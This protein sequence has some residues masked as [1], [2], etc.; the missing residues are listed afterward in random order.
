MNNIHKIK[1]DVR[2]ILA[3]SLC[4]QNDHVLRLQTRTVLSNYF[5]G[6]KY[7]RDISD[8]NVVCDSSNNPP[9]VVNSGN[10]VV[11]LTITPPHAY[12]YIKLSVTVGGNI[13]DDDMFNPPDWNCSTC[14]EEDCQCDNVVDSEATHENG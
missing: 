13:D 1:Q 6:L 3:N 8:F 2:S 9:S 7:N 12:S 10:L 11:D 14:S 4:Q 5:S